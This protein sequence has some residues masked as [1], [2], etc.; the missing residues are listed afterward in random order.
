[1]TEALFRADPYLR[2]AEARVTALTEEGGIILDR[3]IFYPA[4]GG[5]ATLH[6][7]PSSLSRLSLGAR[8]EFRGARIYSLASTD[9]A[10]SEVARRQAETAHDSLAERGIDVLD[11]TTV[12][13]SLEDLFVEYTRGGK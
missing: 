12:E 13:P 3:T 1:M 6:L 5:R 8:G 11:F 2:A 4:G 9:L 7:A 10:D